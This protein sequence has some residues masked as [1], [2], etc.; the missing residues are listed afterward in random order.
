[1][2]C[3]VSLEPEGLREGKAKNKANEESDFGGRK[4]MHGD[5]NVASA[6]FMA[7][8]FLGAVKSFRAMMH[9]Q[10]V[11]SETTLGMGSWLRS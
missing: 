6:R 3:R 8:G 4:A 11:L 9:I 2:L 10:L 5:A 7:E 1:M